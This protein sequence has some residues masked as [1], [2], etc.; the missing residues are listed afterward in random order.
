MLLQ[1]GLALKW[2]A[3]ACVASRT[4]CASADCA[5]D[6]AY[7][8]GTLCYPAAGLDSLGAVEFVNVASRRLNLQLPSTLIFDYVSCQ[9]ATAIHLLP[10]MTACTLS[11]QICP[12]AVAPSRAHAAA[13]PV[14]TRPPLPQKR[15]HCQAGCMA[16]LPQPTS[17]AIT[18]FLMTK[19]AT[20][21]S[22]QQHAAAPQK[23]AAAAMPPPR[24][25]LLPSPGAAE[26][27]IRAVS[28]MGMLLRPFEHAAGRQQPEP[29]PQPPPLVDI[30]VHVP[31]ERW[32]VDAAAGKL[33]GA[34]LPPR[35]GAFM[36][37]VATFDAAAFGL[38]PGEALAMDPQHRLLLEAAGQLLPAAQDSGS[39][40]RQTG[41]FVGISWTEYAQLA[42][43]HG[44][45][46]STYSAQ[47]A[48]LSV[49]CGRIS[50]HCALTG[51]S[52]CVDTACSS[53]LVAAH[54]AR[55][56]LLG[57]GGGS[58]CTSA[59]VGGVNMMLLPSTTAMFAKAGMLAP[60]GRCKTL[61]A[62]ADGYVR[63]EAC[64]MALLAPGA[65]PGALA[66]LRGAAVNQDGRASSLTAPSGPAQQEAVRA[67]LADAQLAEVEVAALQM[68]GTGGW[69]WGWCTAAEGSEGAA[70]RLPASFRILFTHDFT[71]LTPPPN[72]ICRHRAGRP[73]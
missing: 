47:G 31:D 13:L 64:A 46:L 29:L 73:H 23:P 7:S 48:V 30:I 12:P 60:D 45:P 37:S 35:F 63:S 9:V 20:T 38:S 24:S 61:D 18:S 6:R 8:S 40:S 52:L 26:P 16:V 4:A 27:S 28:V 32:A 57:G 14:K 5:V 54:L 21:T 72:I 51:P 62:A 68:H 66:L 1:W 36:S 33:T 22:A 59:L 25:S 70:G 41:V 53:S 56:A 67:A 43:A 2:L 50:Y 10:C 17:S 69:G 3:A 15:P 58:S 19:L 42:A 11:M 39:A 71:S 44:L 49:G 55:Q 65:R 34:A